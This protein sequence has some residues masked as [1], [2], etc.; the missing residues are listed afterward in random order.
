MQNHC[1]ALAH[2]LLGLRVYADLEI[3]IVVVTGKERPAELDEVDLRSARRERR[4]R[5]VLLIEVH[6]L[7]HAQSLQNKALHNVTERVAVLRIA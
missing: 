2:T 5:K 6:I 7:G 3:R 1:G 4:F